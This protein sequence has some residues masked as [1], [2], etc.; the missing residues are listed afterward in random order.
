MST[1]R[2][3]TLTAFFRLASLWLALG[4]IPQSVGQIQPGTLD[5]D[6]GAGFGKVVTQMGAGDDRG[7]ALALQ[8]DGKLVVVGDCETSPLPG[9]SAVCLARYLANG[10]ADSS[11]GTGG[12]A[13]TNIA[14]IAMAVA[15]A[16]NGSLVVAGSCLAPSVADFCVWRF[17]TAGNLDTSFGTSGTAKPNIAQVSTASVA[18]QPDGR[19]VVAGTCVDGAARF[20][21]CV[22]R[23]TTAGLPDAAFATNGKLVFSPLPDNQDAL[24]NALAMQADGK[25]LVA[26]VCAGGGVICV[27]R[28]L[29]NG[30]LDTNGFG[31]LG[32]VT[33]Q[34]NPGLHFGASLAIQ[35]D[36]SI[37]VG[38]TC[39]VPASD[40]AFCL[41]RYLP[42]GAPDSAGFG[43]AGKV[44]ASIGVSADSLKAIAIQADGKIVAAGSCY[45]P[46]LAKLRDEFCAARF[47]SNGALDTGFGSNGVRIDEIAGLSFVE[48]LVLQPD[49]KA[50][51]AGTCRPTGGNQDFCLARYNGGPFA[52]RDCSLDIDGDGA[53]RATSD[54]LIHARIALGM[55][56][57]A[58]VQ[59][60]A[61]ASHAKR[62][63]WASIREYLVTQC[64]V[65]IAP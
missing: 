9:T 48:A 35:P 34:F 7:S 57:A 65:P 46:D 3:A 15:V 8:P 61:F 26:G 6:F 47:H 54:A 20:K 31:T 53:V 4:M 43:S 38:T 5:T 11:F 64:A 63:N 12:K 30:Q 49:G 56:G 39:P 18:L 21:F 58:V 45:N 52:Y 41:A 40:H 1:K 17:D 50:V 33:T 59:G 16:P 51:L 55:T 28:L 32:V 2:S 62:Q 22:A 29:A 19:I 27:V 42:T 10:S 37:V 36:G 44:I 23:L 13:T 24:L 60:I 25:F 14:G